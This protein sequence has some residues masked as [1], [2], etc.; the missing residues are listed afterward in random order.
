MT[1]TQ[2]VAEQIKNV[3]MSISTISNLDP[4]T[5]LTVNT[6]ILIGGEKLIKSPDLYNYIEQGF[7]QLNIT[8]LFLGKDFVLK[9]A[10][11]LAESIHKID[12][13]VPNL[14]LFKTNYEETYQLGLLITPYS[15]INVTEY[16]SEGDLITRFYT[17]T[18]KR[19]LKQMKLKKITD[20]RRRKECID[21][22]RILLSLLHYR[23]FDLRKLRGGIEK[24]KK[25]AYL[26][27]VVIITSKIRQEGKLCVGEC[28]TLYRP[29][30]AQG[31]ICPKCGG[32][33]VDAPP[34]LD[35]KNIRFAFSPKLKTLTS[36]V[37]PLDYF[38]FFIYSEI[39]LAVKLAIHRINPKIFSSVLYIP[40][41]VIFEINSTDDLIDVYTLWTRDKNEITLVSA[42]ADSRL[43]N[44]D[45]P[46]QM[47]ERVFIRD[48][49]EGLEKNLT[50]E[51]IFSKSILKDW[52]L[53]KAFPL[54]YLDEKPEY[55]SWEGLENE[56]R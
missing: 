15:D 49:N 34:T 55:Q 30:E 2:S 51:E 1:N 19:T 3:S 38:S 29:G 22:A 41:R 14:Y 54:K 40:S 44:L 5:G 28:G 53:T 31:N 33:L 11:Y 13:L 48:L 6:P 8:D 17:G 50:F 25:S 32:P 46:S 42:I 36:H 18:F 45:L 9:T 20:S 26:S 39:P 43:K 52:I 37:T 47:S 21:M 10:A 23:I 16:L 7:G 4:N 12:Y 35:I 24:V 56:F 27:A